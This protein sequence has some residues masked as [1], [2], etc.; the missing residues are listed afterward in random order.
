MN[1]ADMKSDSEGSAPAR[2]PAELL[3]EHLDQ[4][5]RAARLMLDARWGTEPPGGWMGSLDGE[6]HWRSMADD[7]VNSFWFT[8]REARVL[9]D[10]I[11]LLRAALARVRPQEAELASAL[12]EYAEWCGGVH[13][14]GCPADDT[15]LRVFW[16]VD[17]RRRDGRSQSPA[18][19]TLMVPVQDERGDW[20]CEHGTAVDVHCCNCHSGF[21]FDSDSCV[22]EFGGTDG[23]AEDRRGPVDRSNHAGDSRAHQTRS[24]AAGESPLQPRVVEGPGNSQPSDQVAVSPVPIAPEPEG[25]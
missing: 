1:K 12:E 17:Q 5:Y 16:E 3:A 11:E 9:L 13:D 21:L 19:S 2:S 24:A 20:V 14:D 15:C 23:N 6:A 7:T 22:C 8:N 10:Q 25:E 18:R 4:A